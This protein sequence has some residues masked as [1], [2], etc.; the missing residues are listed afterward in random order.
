MKFEFNII[1]RSLI[2]LLVGFSYLPKQDTSD[3]TELNIYLL[4]IVLHF[5]FY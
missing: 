2:G 5:K 3:Y 1:D 4:I